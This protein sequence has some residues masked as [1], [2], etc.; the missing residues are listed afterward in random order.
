MKPLTTGNTA[1]LYC[2]NWIENYIKDNGDTVRIL[3][4]GSGTSGNFVEL[5]QRYPD[6]T[7]VGIEPYDAACEKARRDLK[8]NNVTIINDSAYDIMG[9]LVEN[10]FDIIVSFSV[11]EHVVQRQRFLD[12]AAA[13]MTDKSYFLI[14]Y[15][16]GHFVHPG[17]M[18]ERLKNIIGPMLAQVG[19]ERYFQ[20]FM[21]EGDFEKMV[22]QSDMK[23]TEAKSFNTALKGIHKI[24]PDV[25][26]DDH[27]QRWLDYELWLNEIG[28]PYE[29][30]LAKYWVTRNFI[31][32]KS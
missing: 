27:L 2:I 28:T 5:L 1:K 22:K 18:K 29:D 11:M 31:I 3:D 16:A 13:C 8:G 19:I 30:N 20:K 21:R 6:L 9:R 4:L 24:V 26:K 23:I 25:Y 10:P 15:D 14:N 7:Y 17:S 12:S 32:Q